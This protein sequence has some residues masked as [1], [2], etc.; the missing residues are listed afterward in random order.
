MI[1]PTKYAHPDKTVLS[2]SLIILEKLK[3]DKI[4]KYDKL[5]NHIKNRITAGVPLYLPALNFLFLLGVIEYYPKTDSIVYVG[6][7]ENI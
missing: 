2:I 6:K 4:I 7:N 1:R 3:K 5:Q